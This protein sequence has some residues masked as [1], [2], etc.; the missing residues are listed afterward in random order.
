MGQL[1]GKI[2][3]LAVCLGLIAS[4]PA[5][6]ASELKWTHYGVRPL[7]M[8]NAYVA[9]ADDFNALFYNPAGLARLKSWSGE[10]LNPSVSISAN[11]V[12]AA[13]SIGSLVSSSGGTGSTED[14][15]LRVLQ[16]NT[17]KPQYFNV[18]ETPHLIFPGFGIGIG[19]VSYTHLALPTKRIV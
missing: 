15:V 13:S 5:T 8:G 18:T 7:A 17:G 3:K 14:G 6:F 2:A 4:A 1:V 11:T 16:D 12:G 9:V 10:L 19:P